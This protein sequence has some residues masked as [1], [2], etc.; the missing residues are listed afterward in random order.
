[1]RQLR[2]LNPTRRDRFRCSLIHPARKD[3]LPDLTPVRPT[4]TLALELPAGS[5]HTSAALRADAI[6][7]AGHD[8]SAC[9]FRT[10]SA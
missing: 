9:L 2:L 3:S 8:F 4:L 6:Q 10:P 1:M 5:T 7:N